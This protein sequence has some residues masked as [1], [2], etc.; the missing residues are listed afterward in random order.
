MQACEALRAWS[1]RCGGRRCGAVQVA[2][3]AQWLAQDQELRWDFAELHSGSALMLRVLLPA[4]ADTRSTQ[5]ARVRAH[6]TQSK[7]W[8]SLC[9][10]ALTGSGLS[11][12]GTLG[13]SP[14]DGRRQHQLTM[15]RERQHHLQATA[16][17][18]P[19]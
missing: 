15:P 8:M 5:G 11:Q 4:D 3:R 17:C 6:L 14:E 12:A 16:Q 19:A 2:P 7:M 1:R 9:L 13:Q 10:A 18:M